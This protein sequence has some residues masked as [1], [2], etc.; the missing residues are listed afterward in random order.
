MKVWIRI[1]PAITNPNSYLGFSPRSPA[2]NEWAANL[3][4]VEARASQIG[5][6]SLAPCLQL[7]S[8]VTG[9]VHHRWPDRC[10]SFW[11]LLVYQ[12]EVYL[13]VPVPE[14]YGVVGDGDGLWIGRRAL[15]HDKAVVRVRIILVTKALA[16]HCYCTVDRTHLPTGYDPSGWLRDGATC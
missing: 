4:H 2:G 14:E 1:S 8:P 12:H 11:G 15:P 9:C 6:E 7:D 5:H 16:Q 3:L 10:T 13:P